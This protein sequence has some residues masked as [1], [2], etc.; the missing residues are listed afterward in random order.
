M[1][2]RTKFKNKNLYT[3]ILFANENNHN[4]EYEHLKSNYDIMEERK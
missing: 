4:K 1:K 2:K 3:Y